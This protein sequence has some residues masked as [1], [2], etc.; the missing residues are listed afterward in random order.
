[1]SYVFRN[2]IPTVQPSDGD[3]ISNSDLDRLLGP[4][5]ATRGTNT[6]ALEQ[7]GR[8]KKKVGPGN[9]QYDCGLSAM[10]AQ[11]VWCDGSSVVNTIIH[12]FWTAL[13]ICNH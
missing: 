2:I 11:R 1:M 12:P 10:F 4:L 13:Y 6:S 8:E 9:M 7:E 3:S 5:S